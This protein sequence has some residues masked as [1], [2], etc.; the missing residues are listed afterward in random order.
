MEHD[1]D[2]GLKS[3]RDGTLLTV[4]FSLR[5]GD[6]LSPKSRR[7]DTFCPAPAHGC[8]SCLDRGLC[9]VRKTHAHFRYRRL[10]PT[11]NKVPSLR[12]YQTIVPQS[13]KSLKSL[14]SPKSPRRAAVRNL[15]CSG[16][17]PPLFRRGT[18][19]VSSWNLL[20]FVV[21]PPL[22]RLGTSFASTRNLLCFDAEPPLLRCG[23]SFVTLHNQVGFGHNPNVE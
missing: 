6:S 21:E 14:K 12:D 2:I 3:R 5:I 15:L 20:C 13:L 17:E 10:K 23:T 16:A 7:D 8:R 1:N 9:S 4:G 22:F 11:V 18:S 19:F